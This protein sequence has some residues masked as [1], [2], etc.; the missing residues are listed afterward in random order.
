MNAVNEFEELRPFLFSIA[1][2]TLG[3]VVEAEDVVQDA[4]VRY[5]NALDRGPEVHSPRAFLARVVARLSVDVL[6]SA[7]VRRE[8]YVGHWFPEPLPTNDAAAGPDPLRSVEAAESVSTAALILL[9]SL[10]PLERAAFVLHDV[11]DFPFDDIAE[12]LDRSPAACRQLAARARKH[13]REGS[14][15]FDADLA[16]REELAQRFLAAIHAGDIAGLQEHLADEVDLLNDSGGA[17]G[18][19]GGRFAAATAA[20]LLI[21]SSRPLVDAGARLEG[22]EFNGAPG[23]VAYDANG[24]IICTWTLEF[25]GGKISRLYSLTNPA[26]LGHLGDVGDFAEFVREA[27]QGTRRHPR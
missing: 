20:R 19:Q 18:G 15:R 23:A 7:R 17:A 26:K 3:S 2:R 13:V 12:S 6:R 4:W 5:Q 11:F 9:E 10:S 1:Y 21:V 14:K 16:A 24:K 27:R 22:R 25:A 8:T